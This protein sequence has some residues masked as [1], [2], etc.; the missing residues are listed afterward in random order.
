MKRRLSLSWLAAAISSPWL[1]SSAWA[2]DDP[3]SSDKTPAGP[4]GKPYDVINPPV[5]ADINKVRFLFSY[6]C[7]YCRGYHNGVA[8]WGSTLPKPL[9]FEATPVITSVA[10]ENQSLAVFGRLVTQSMAPDK[11]P[12]YDS[13][14]YSMLQGEI[15]SGI[16]PKARITLADVIRVLVAVGIDPQ[17]L[18]TFLD[19]RGAS[20]GRRIPAYGQLVQTYEMTAT[21]SVALVGRYLVT[22][23]HAN[24]NAQQFLLLLNGLVS[25]ILQGGP[26]AL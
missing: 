26:N 4:S 8:Q 23:D 10:N 19:K 13:A 21:P 15:E 9:K 18:Q 6:E 24:G 12:V 14:M 16:A 20:L 25:R 17:A 22:P 5:A 11:V 1:T 2:F 7:P 3:T